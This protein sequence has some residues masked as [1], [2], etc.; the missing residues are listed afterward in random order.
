MM[1]RFR[2]PLLTAVAVGMTALALALPAQAQSSSP[3]G[4]GDEVVLRVGVVADLDTDN[5][6]AVSGG[7]D[8]LAAT[9]QYDMLLNFSP[10]DLTAGTSGIANGCT[11]DAEFKVW[12]CDIKQG[13]K[14]SDGEPLTAA[15]VMFSFNFV[16]NNKIPQYKSYFASHPTFS[17]PDDHTLV[18]TSPEPTFAPEMPPWVY[19]VPEHDW[20]QYDGK[21]LKEIRAVKGMDTAVSGPFKLTQWTPGQGWT[22]TKNP[23]FRGPDPTID[24]IDYRVYTNG[25]AMIQALKN[26]EIDIADGLEPG[27][28]ASIGNSQDITVQKVVSDWWLNLAFNFGGQPGSKY[29]P[30]PALH[31][32]T[33]RE[34]IEMAI[35]KNAIVNKVYQG[36]ATP[37]DTIV[38]PA[39]TFWHLDIPADQEI[40]FDPQQAN[41]M[42][43][44]AGYKDTNGDGIRE[45][46]N[47][48]GQPLVMN[49]PASTDTTGAEQAGE[50]IVGFLKQIGIK[51]NLEPA[52]DSKMNDYWYS[53]NFDAYIW[54]WSG[55]PDPNYQ[56][57]VFTSDQCGAW[58]D[59]CWK[60]AQFDQLYQQQNKEMDQT[61]RQA[62]VKQAQQ[63]AY[64]DI[65][66][67]VLAYPNWL[68][69]YRNDR[70]TDWTPSPGQ[71]GYLLPTYNYDT[72]LTAKPIAGVST[73]GSSSSLPGWVWAVIVVVIA[74]IV[75]LI[76]RRGRRADV[77][78]A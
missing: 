54:Y 76:V 33:V 32:H 69:A 10:S 45:D 72:L 13:L 63:V 68:S 27:L 4:S 7:S 77:E 71:D 78:E 11:P 57:F 29:T 70:F 24:R 38:R 60:N 64:D 42:L 47:N 74:A 34:A 50:L 6:F 53:G 18:W 51:V 21:P 43:D 25:E 28:I 31:D 2:T 59:G 15:D 40:P 37:G 62:L 5:V 36:A 23:Y 39:S 58:E 26:G 46:P 3:S 66:G 19:I 30:L 56:L 55:D 65:P 52:T 17:T 41:D 44:Q 49:M 73:S 48:G 22:L 14:W 67:V 1:K 75:V 61:A 8:W 12:T 20:A 9:T 35:D 16:I